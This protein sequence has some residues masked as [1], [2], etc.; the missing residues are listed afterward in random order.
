ML[1]AVSFKKEVI[2]TC[3]TASDE[4]TVWMDPVSSPACTAQRLLTSV[5]RFTSSRGP[6]CRAQIL[7]LHW[8]L[9]RHGYGHLVVHTVNSATCEEV[10][11]MRSRALRLGGRACS[12]RGLWEGERA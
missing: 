1:E 9:E 10:R 8:D 7:Q 12:A 3:L 4:Q 5:R 2:L 11:A 6:C